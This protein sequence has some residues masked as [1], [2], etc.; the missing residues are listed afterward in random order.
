MGPSFIRSRF[1]APLSLLGTSCLL[2][3]TDGLGVPESDLKMSIIEFLVWA[4]P[5]SLGSIIILGSAPTYIRRDNQRMSMG[6]LLIAGSWAVIFSQTEKAD[7]SNFISG[8]W[9]SIGLAIGLTSFFFAISLAERF[10]GI[11][12]ESEPLSQSERDLVETILIRR[13]RRN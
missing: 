1:G 3:L 8:I 5:F 13:M 9:I 7:L 6:W 4:I 11:S 12:N 10:S 2:L